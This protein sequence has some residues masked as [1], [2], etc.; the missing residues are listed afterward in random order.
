[1]KRQTAAQHTDAADKRSMHH[2]RSTAHLA[3]LAAHSAPSRAGAVRARTRS[4]AERTQ[5][6]DRRGVPGS[7][8]PRPSAAAASKRAVREWL[9]VKA[10]SDVS[11][12]GG[13]RTGWPV[14]QLHF[15]CRYADGSTACTRSCS[16]GSTG[17]SGQSHAEMVENGD[18]ARR[19]RHKPKPGTNRRPAQTEA[20]YKP[21]PADTARANCVLR[22]LGHESVIE[23][24]SRPTDSNPNEADSL[25]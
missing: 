11:A 4:A 15:Q 6:V 14:I 23:S 20:R 8:P 22:S 16:T 12:P 1:M 13:R 18:G 21:K 10:C 24:A 2:A 7:V 25:G 9:C 3:R 5:L 19:R 17:P